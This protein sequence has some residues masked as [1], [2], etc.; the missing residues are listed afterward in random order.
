VAEV[1]PDDDSVSRYYAYDPARHERRHQTIIAFDHRVA[2]ESYI[3]D[4]IDRLR[5]RQ[6]ADP[7]V[8]PRENYS[9][10]SSR[11]AWIT[12]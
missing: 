5:T 9:G 8:D 2:F 10:V 11:A 6:A 1:D 3:H 4:A 7:D 12:T